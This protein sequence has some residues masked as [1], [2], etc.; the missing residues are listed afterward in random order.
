MS[1]SRGVGRRDDFV[2]VFTF[3]PAALASFAWRV[4]KVW[5]WLEPRRR[6]AAAC[7]MSRLR[8]PRRSEWDA[9]SRSASIM[10]EFWGTSA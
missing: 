7:N 4:S 5:N 1:E 3:R 9:L 2:Y 10:S 6:A 8:V